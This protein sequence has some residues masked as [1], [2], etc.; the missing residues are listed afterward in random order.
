MN[1]LFLALVVLPSMVY[2]LKIYFPLFFSL[3]LLAPNHQVF[4]LHYQ[5]SWV[6]MCTKKDLQAI[7][8][9]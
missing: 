9:C 7:H 6:T 8:H 5:I 3:V 2:V 4:L 1:Q